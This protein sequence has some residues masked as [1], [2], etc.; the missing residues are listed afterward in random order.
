MDASHAWKLAL[1]TVLDNGRLV[2]PR[3][4]DTFEVPQYTTKVDMSAPV[5]RIKARRLNY[6]F[7]AAEAYWILSGDDKVKSIAPYNK[8]IANFSDDGEVFFGAY[9]PKIQ[10]QLH[11]VVDKIRQ[12]L[13]T[14]QAGLTIWRECPPNTKDVPCT[15]AIFFSVRGSSL[16]AHVF[17]RSSDV[18]L[19][20][21]YD[22]FNFSMLGHLVC[23]MLNHYGIHLYP[24]QLY[25]TAA[26]SHLY[27]SNI[28]DVKGCILEELTRQ[29]ITPEPL[30]T[31]PDELM[32]TLRLLRDS[33][34]GDNLRW[35]EADYVETN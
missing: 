5:V 31:R 17:M 20:L 13:A 19:G 14:R 6:S 21:P 35:W 22:I 15:V 4:K 25:V 10:N 33:R 7:M 8:H 11:Y 12:D 2:S 1:T 34:P 16:N 24:G 18:W 29:I 26:S 27:H 3:G 32:H 28:K 23:G 30:F 9:G